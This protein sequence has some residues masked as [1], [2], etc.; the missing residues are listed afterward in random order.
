MNTKRKE[1]P[2]SSQL[3]GVQALL[4]ELPNN[5]STNHAAVVDIIPSSTPPRYYFDPEKQQQLV[6]SVKPKLHYK[7]K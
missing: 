6:Q 2:Y 3:K 1:Q 4:G 5:Q 7:Y